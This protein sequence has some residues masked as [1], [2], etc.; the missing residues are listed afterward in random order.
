MGLGLHDVR[1]DEC[2]FVSEDKTNFWQGRF[3][4]YE[5]TTVWS[6]TGYSNDDCSY[7]G[8]SVC[9][10]YNVSLAL[11]IEQ[12]NVFSLSFAVAK[13]KGKLLHPV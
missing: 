3:D 5:G 7:V 6:S 11:P 10:T 12:M 8:E 9:A 2:H 1:G 4:V 13:I